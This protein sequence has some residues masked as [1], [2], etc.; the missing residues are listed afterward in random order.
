M[1][2]TQGPRPI[3]QYV[4][5]L[6]RPESEE[7]EIYEQLHGLDPASPNHTLPCDVVRSGAEQPF[8]IMPCLDDIINPDH[9]KWG[10]VTLLDFFRQVIEVSLAYVP[11]SRT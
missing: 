3:P 8:L 4:V 6:V 7:A 10:I 2:R 1:W 9:L 5:K 11:R